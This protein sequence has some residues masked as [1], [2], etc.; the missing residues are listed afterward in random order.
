MSNTNSKAENDYLSQSVKY[1]QK[2]KTD[3]PNEKS[4]FIQVQR[5][6]W[7]KSIFPNRFY[8]CSVFLCSTCN[9][10]SRDLS[11]C[12]Q[13]GRT[14]CGNHIADHHCPPGFGVDIATQQLFIY[15]PDLGRRFIFDAYIDHLII[16]A[17]LAVIDGIPM[18]VKID[19]AGS[20]FPTRREPMPLQNLGNTCWLNSLFQCLVVNPLLQKWFLSSTINITRVECAE[21]A[22]H[23]HLCRLFLA[24]VS[25]STFSQADCLFAIWSLLPIFATSDQ[26]DAHEFLMQLRTK[27]DDFYQQKF[28]T[29]IFNGIF[30]WQFKVIESCENCDETRTFIDPA[31]DLILNVGSCSS[32]IEAFSEFLLGAS[33]LPCNNCQKPCKRQYFFNTLPPTL[34]IQLGRAQN[35][36]KGLAA[37]QLVEELSLDDFVDIDKKAELGE[38]KYSLIGL[39]VRPGSGDSG[40]YYADV[41]KWGQWYRC[42]D[43]NVKAV[44]V[45]DVMQ[46]DASLLF[47][48]R[49]GFVTQ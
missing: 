32:L 24:Q 42:D 48:V 20:I 36:E 16:A 15:E 31:S 38:A 13:C 7:E 25:E 12:L 14:F 22:V 49:K 5:L 17:K 41:K 34:T 40:H 6:I 35:M 43:N 27:L 3:S 19:N 45:S 1:L 28:E 33:P 30:S 29:S 2:F 37:V 23:L 46:D 26:F 44:D 18:Q 47:Y 21:A 8:S 10:K 4:T 11:F 39:V 9:C